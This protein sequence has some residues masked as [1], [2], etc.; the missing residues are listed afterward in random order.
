MPPLLDQCAHLG[1]QDIFLDSSLSVSL[2]CFPSKL[3]D[4]ASDRIHFDRS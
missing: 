4:R 3:L 2:I 1:E